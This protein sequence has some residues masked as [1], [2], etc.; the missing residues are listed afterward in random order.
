[1]PLL[2]CH[3]GPRRV[4]VTADVRVERPE[5]RG[6]VVCR[7]TWGGRGRGLGGSV[8]AATGAVAWGRCWGGAW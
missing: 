8:V 7:E 3:V 4:C 6:S 2:V 1:M 5:R